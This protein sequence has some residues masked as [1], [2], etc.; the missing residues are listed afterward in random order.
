MTAT[1]EPGELDPFTLR[2]LDDDLEARFQ[3]EEGEAGRSGY[4]IITAASVLLWL[5]AVVLF[6]I[7]SDMPASLTTPVGLVMASVG[8]FAL[9][10]DRWVVTMDRQH[11]VAAL[12]TSANGLAV[13]Y[14]MI[15]GGVVE[16]FAAAAL[17]LIFV[18]GFVSRT[19]FV[20]ALFRTAVI[21]AG[22]SVVVARSDEP[23]S[24]LIDVFFL[25]TAA[26][27]SLLGLRRL[28]RDRRFLWHQERVIEAQ[29]AAIEAER[30]ESERLLLNVLPE[31]VSRRLRMGESPIADDYPNVSILF[32]DIV[33]FTRKA[34]EMS[35]S[36]VVGLVDGLFTM[37]DHLVVR[38]G[39]EKIKTVGDAYMAAAGLP[40][41]LEDHARRI[42][43]LGIEMIRHTEAFHLT[44]DLAIRVGIHSGPVTGGVVGTQ[45]F[46][47]D[48][49]GNTVNVA[50][51][52]QQTADPGRVHVSEETMR[53]CGDG[54]RFE[55]AAS[56]ELK[57][58]GPIRTYYVLD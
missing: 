30:A 42:V 57:G 26:A 58:L 15:A 20:F 49:W 40:E 52:I 48:V 28:E 10:L 16:R 50:A 14:L 32:A 45:K 2:F 37:F 44:P 1:S 8:I 41:P 31:P 9:A 27:A 21:L 7:G 13:L 43:S 47:F 6:P 29:S 22:Y 12:L 3:R 54:Y 4:R 51:R 33:D 35:A 46:A 18:F 55:P 25:V 24:L 5:I 39:L 11:L 23:A 19:R 34:S 38:H 17:I 36:E 53:Q 56:S